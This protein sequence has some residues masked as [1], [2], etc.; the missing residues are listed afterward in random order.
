M[1]RSNYTGDLDKDLFS[2]ALIPDAVAYE[3]SIEKDVKEYIVARAHWV[4]KANKDWGRRIAPGDERARN[5]LWSF[6]LHWKAAYIS[7]PERAKKELARWR[8][9]K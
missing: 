2:K 9:G 3:I 8:A 4:Y 7:N 6:M 1:T 5:L